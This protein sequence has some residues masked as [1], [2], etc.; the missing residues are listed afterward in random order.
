METL[1]QDVRH[2][3]RK[4][5]QGPPF[6]IVAI[7]TLALGIGANTAI[8]SVVNSI[9]L[10]PLPY[11][12]PDRLARLTLKF[13]DGEGQAVSIPKFMAWKE[14]TQAFQYK[15]R[16]DGETLCC[17]G[18]SN[19]HSATASALF[20]A[21]CRHPHLQQSWPELPPVFRTEGPDKSTRAGNRDFPPAR[22]LHPGS[23]LPSRESE[24][25]RQGIHRQPFLDV[26]LASG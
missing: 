17:A 13:R 8:F 3:V 18:Y 11:S 26:D 5:A 1:L 4:L 21:Q 20:T 12:Q 6:T 19:P 7:A 15:C 22:L 10:Q 25:Q 9:L 23:F 16:C 2:A 14:H 24:R